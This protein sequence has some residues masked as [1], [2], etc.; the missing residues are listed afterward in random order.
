MVQAVK[1]SGL[2]HN[3]HKK[4][5]TIKMPLES[6]SESSLL[7][8]FLCPW[9]R[10]QF[11]SDLN[12]LSWPPWVLTKLLHLLWHQLSPLKI[13]ETSARGRHVPKLYH[14]T[15]SENLKNSPKTPS[16]NSSESWLSRFVGR[17]KI[18][19]QESQM[20]ENKLCCG[21]LHFLHKMLEKAL[22][23][24]QIKREKKHQINIG[25]LQYL[26][27]KKNNI[28]PLPVSLH[29]GGQVILNPFSS[30]RWWP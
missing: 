27:A 7:F 9:A 23:W 28:F 10:E 6:F 25:S 19:R 5:I 16:V 2:P 8:S 1:K 11:F 24:S 20:A 13:P 21:P 29:D 14:N 17:C 22:Y 3:T 4:V 15:P 30:L 18:W 26:M 12:H